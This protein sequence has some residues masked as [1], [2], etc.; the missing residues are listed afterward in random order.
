M[1]C[2]Q[3]AIKYSSVK[4]IVFMGVGTG[5]DECAT[6][7]EDKTMDLHSAHAITLNSTSEPLHFTPNEQ[8]SRVPDFRK[9][10][11]HRESIRIISR[12]GIR[13]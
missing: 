3:A 10:A 9:L 5:K 4:A 13:A 8:Q 6:L 7:S 12:D 11:T 2:L 1:P